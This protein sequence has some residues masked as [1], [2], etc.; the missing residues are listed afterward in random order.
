MITLL[1][2]A[3]SAP[4]TPPAP[5]EVEDL[6]PRTYRDQP[7]STALAVDLPELD[8]WLADEW[9]PSVPGYALDAL[10]DADVAGLTRPDRSLEDAIGGEA[11]AASVHTL[12][13]HVAFVMQTDQS[14]VNPGD[15][16]KFDRSFLE[17][18]DCFA[19]RACDVLRTWND[20]T[21][22]AAFGV[23][24]PYAYEKDYRRVY[25]TDADGESREAVV[26]RGWVEQVSLSDDGAN[27][28]L[29]SYNLDVFLAQ[30][31][32][33]VVRVQAQWAEMKLS[34]D[35]FVTDEFLFDQLID[36]LQGV[37]TD[38]DAAIDELGL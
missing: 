15:Y 35:D 6:C 26:S 10:T 13:Q 14:V 38:T 2:A 37:F 19:T 29:Q 16:A 1:L 23:I 31:D 21:K 36:G 30:P 33:G 20:I 12:D 3:C 25:Y 18:G 5:A 24:I 4:E 28:I 32:G 17:G 22:T 34:I 9:D 27:G 7:D 8:T 11:A